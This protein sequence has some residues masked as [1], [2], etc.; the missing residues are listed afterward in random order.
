MVVTEKQQQKMK[1][2]A[3]LLKA[4]F[5]YL[6]FPTW[7]EERVLSF[8]QT[9]AQNADLIKTKREVFT[10]TLTQGV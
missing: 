7:E 3:D 5:P 10:W 1:Q 4:R 2:L 9:V 8:I 6:Y